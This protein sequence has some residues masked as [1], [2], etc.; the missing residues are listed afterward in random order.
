[1]NSAA[2]SSG[3]HWAIGHYDGQDWFSF[4]M[5]TTNKRIAT[6]KVRFEPD[7]S[8]WSAGTYASASDSRLKKL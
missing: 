8:V 5:R 4:S 1:M 2:K 6:L 7:G 3:S